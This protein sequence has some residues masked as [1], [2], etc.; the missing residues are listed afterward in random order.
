MRPKAKALG[1]LDALQNLR[2]GG[3]C[4][5]EPWDAQEVLGYQ[6]PLGCPRGV[7]LVAV[8]GIL[9]RKILGGCCGVDSVGVL[10]LRCASLR[11]TGLGWGLGAGG[12]GYAGDAGVV[13]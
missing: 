4:S 1:Y 2:L 6:R 8:G 11:M 5:Y 3:W 7:G 9:V 10:R 13:V 12:E